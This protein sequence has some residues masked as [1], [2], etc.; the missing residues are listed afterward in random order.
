MTALI[1]WIFDTIH[2]WFDKENY[3]VYLAGIKYNNK[4][5]IIAMIPE[6]IELPEGYELLSEPMPK[7]KAETRID[8]FPLWRVVA[9]EK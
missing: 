8:S 5:I 2:G 4:Y 1:N 9:T 6:N 7:N 3:S